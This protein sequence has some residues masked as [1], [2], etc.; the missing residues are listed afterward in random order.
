MAVFDCKVRRGRLATC[1]TCIDGMQNRQRRA[2]ERLGTLGQHEAAARGG[3]G[4]NDLIKI[5][6]QTY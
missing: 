6:S 1:L 2:R 3:A 4:R 5:F